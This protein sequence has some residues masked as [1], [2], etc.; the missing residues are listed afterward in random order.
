MEIKKRSASAERFCRISGQIAVLVTGQGHGVGAAEDQPFGQLEFQRHCT[1]AG[2]KG[3]LLIAPAVVG[4]LLGNALG[5]HRNRRTV[6]AEHDGHFDFSDNCVIFFD[7]PS[8]YGLFIRGT[9]RIVNGNLI[10]TDKTIIKNKLIMH[11][12]IC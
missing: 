3:G 2:G 10:Y 5:Y 7:C 6:I 1:A 12:N 4:I 8:S 11:D 9:Y